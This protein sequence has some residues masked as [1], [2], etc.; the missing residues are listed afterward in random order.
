M[1]KTHMSCY[2]INLTKL[3]KNKMLKN[4]YGIIIPHNKYNILFDY[5]GILIFMLLLLIK[6]EIH[7]GHAYCT[8][9]DKFLKII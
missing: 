2:N 6:Q 5:E 1:H 8:S 4:A 7:F 9:L 3:K